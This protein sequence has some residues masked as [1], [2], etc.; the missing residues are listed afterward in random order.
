M[1]GVSWVP[2]TGEEFAGYHLISL[3][4]HGGMS[5]VYQAEHR[6]LGRIV[7]LKILSPEMSESSDFRERF[8]RESRVAASLEHPNIIPIYEAGEENGVLFIAMRYVAGADLRAQL[9]RDGAFD[10]DKAVSL[11]SQVAA[12]L[13]AAHEKNLIHRDVKPANILVAAA[14]G[15]RGSDHFYLSDF[16]VTKNTVS[17]GLTR[18]GFFVGTADYAAPEQIEGKPLDARADV[19]AL[20]CVAYEALTATPAFQ[21][22]SEV[23][24]MYAHL[25]EAP[26][27]VSEKRPD[28]GPEVDY[29]IAR[30]MAK[31]VDDRFSRPTEFALALEGA[32]AAAP[33]PQAVAVAPGAGET[34]LANVAASPAPT[35]STQAPAPPVQ[36]PPD[37]RSDSSTGGRKG[38]P[39]RAILAAA[40]LAVVAGVA[41]ILAIVLGGGSDPKTQ[42]SG[43]T[44]APGTTTT[45]ATVPV[46]NPTLASV[47]MPTQISKE[48]KAS[49]QPVGGAIATVDCVPPATGLVSDPDQLQFS[50]YSGSQPL[51]EDYRRL[52]T[53][54]HGGAGQNKPLAK[55][56]TN[57]AGQKT[58]GHPTGMVGGRRFCFTDD[59]GNYVIVWTHEKRGSEDH[60]DMLGTAREPGRS[61]TI[62]ASWWA[63]A[64]NFIGKC[65]PQV[66]QQLCLDTIEKATG[67]R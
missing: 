60:V 56:G 34:V 38:M 39:G 53:E 10:R 18:T 14:S 28:I 3:I 44:T 25:L 33:P 20:G 26:P 46:P 29:V 48:C 66:A 16:G 15:P 61:P 67:K 22:D 32:L 4:G 11:I 45:T 13:E 64:K 2:R 54:A 50:F 9:K 1:S 52:L 41:V 65:R 57:A 5:I 30:A 40:A 59:K 51:L 36:P 7:A 47:L 42:A 6:A 49:A 43:T 35:G 55:C 12:A 24:M 17:P 62:Y 19:Y 37:S 27:K 31:S 63:S 21:K 58:W 8:Q 23:S